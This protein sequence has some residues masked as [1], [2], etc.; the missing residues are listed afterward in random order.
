MFKL[1]III[2]TFYLIL[3]GWQ[4]LSDKYSQIVY[5]VILGII[6]LGLGSAFIS[7]SLSDIVPDRFER[8][9]EIKK[10]YFFIFFTLFLTAAIFAD[11]LR[12]LN[13]FFSI[14][15]SVVR[16]NYSHAKTIYFLSVVLFS[17][18]ISVTGFRNYFN[19]VINDVDLTYSADSFKV[20]D[21][22][23]VAASDFHLGPLIGTDRLVFWTGMINDQEPDLILLVGDIFDYRFKQ[24]YSTEVIAELKKL[25]S[26]YG[27]YAVPGNHEY[28]FGIKRSIEYLEKAGI[29]VLRDTAITIDGRITLIGRD[30]ADNRRRESLESLLAGADTSLPI[31]LMDHQPVDLTSAV[32]N[33]IDLQISGHTH[34]GQ[35]FPGNYLARLK[36]DLVYGHR[37]TG[38]TDFYVTSGIG[39]SMIPLRLGTRSELVRINL[40]AQGEEL[41]AQSRDRSEAEIPHQRKQRAEIGAKRRFRISGSEEQ[42]FRVSGS[43]GQ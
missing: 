36:W 30:D 2:I 4:A 21:M 11:L 35:I 8:S 38:N 24:K 7:H 14:F 26:V 10:S 20:G 31:V 23:I 13:H 27:V 42:R 17:V 43:I 34:N 40:K 18:V 28:S 3:R 29:N 9:Y 37:K 16:K 25:R 19:P 1:F 33:R 41:R 32:R 39:L 22:N 15:P 6:L 5:S 12:I